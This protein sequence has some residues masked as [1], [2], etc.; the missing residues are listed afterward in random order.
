MN[1]LIS[2][3]LFA[4]AGIVAQAA[5]KCLIVPQPAE[6]QEGQGYCR[7]PGKLVVSGKDKSSRAAA[8]EMAR[9]L[10]AWDID[11][12]SGTN[13]NVSVL[14]ASSGMR[15]EQYRLEVKPEGIAITAGD[16][17]GVFYAVQTLAQ[18]IRQSSGTEGLKCCTIND[19]PRFEY[20]GMML[21]VVRCYIPSSEILKMID[22]A[23]KL[24]INKV[25][26][27][28]TDDNG[29]RLEIKKYPKLTEVGA[30]RVYREEVFPGRL[31]ARSADEPTPVGGF[32]TQK[33]MRQL[34]KYAAERHITIIPEIEMPAH[35]AGAIASYPELACPVDEKF[36]GVFPGIGG[37]DASI[38]CC[39]GNE[40]VYTF[41]QDVLDEV[42]DIFPSEYIHL[43][44][45][46]A[47][48]SHWEK[49][50]LCNERI[51]KENLANFEELQAY[52]MDRINHYV[53]EKGRTA[54]G[55]DEVTYGNPKED[56]VIF[57]WQGDGSVAVKDARRSGRRFVLTPAQLLYLLRYQGP[58]WF[59]PFTYFGNSILKD[60]YNFEPM[61][62]DWDEA[63]KKQLWGIQGSLWT[64]FCDNAQ[65]MQYLLFPRIL[66]V[67]DAA[68]RR[69]G[70]ADWG[71]F[72]KAMDAF[73]PVLDENG[74]T[75]SR[76]MYNVA[77]K[78]KGN[79]KEL[80]VSLK[81]ERPD[82]DVRY[83]MQKEDLSDASVYKN[84]L[85]IGKPCKIYASTFKDG[86]QQ[87]KTLTLDLNFNKATAKSISSPN[88][89][90]GLV[91]VLTNG[92]R[93]SG[94]ATDF[95]WAGWHNENAEIIVDL[96]EPTAIG[97]VSLGA[98]VHA[99]VCVAAPK[100]V[101]VYTS[102][103]GNSYRLRAS[104][105]IPD[106]TVF[107][108]GTKLFDIDCGNIGVEARYVKLVAVNPGCFPDG[109]AREGVASWMYFD[110]VVIE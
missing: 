45:D 27:H 80:E 50:P 6:Y 63:L 18:L 28:L 48:K 104:V 74:I 77:H 92:L 91:N 96:G 87:G 13:G 49:C 16:Q 78:V 66:A 62:P 44:G 95:E 25:H 52:F 22:I 76:A 93:G 17:A 110:E 73:L 12:K 29:W 31:N 24:K 2:I 46:E 47:N 15:P 55:W 57:G 83:S 102:D 60:V 21:D 85:K 26:L 35:A 105:S 59:E 94:K 67:A 5:P 3:I 90:N 101:F 108:A 86:K 34:V 42:M 33:E 37:K 19:Y 88:C 11:A 58:Q 69:Q 4:L 99:D 23:A 68:W 51:K 79:G 53:R 32:Y 1:K 36:V 71:A 9:Y 38:I 30:W 14:M 72:V 56:M 100:Q 84:E 61:K 41:Y 107:H 54:I 7:L 43:G 39:A 8:K 40:K 20:R 98:L 89:R 65:D 75:Y 64:E 70:S 82:V 10:S 103:K 81:C 109:W 106:E 97:R